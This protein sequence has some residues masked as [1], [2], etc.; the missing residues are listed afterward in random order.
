MDEKSKRRVE[1]NQ[2][3]EIRREEIKS[4][5]I[6]EFMENGIEKS[7]IYDIA[8]RAGVGEATIY[9]YFETKPKL[10]IQSAVKLWRNSVEELIPK[11]SSESSKNLN[12][13]EKIEAILKLFGSIFEK[14]PALLRLLEQFDNYIVKECVPMEQLQQFA[15]GILHVRAVTA[16]IIR[17]GQRDGSIRPEIDSS[18]FYLSS[19]Q[20]ILTLSQKLLMRG[21]IIQGEEGYSPKNQIADL[22]DMQLY[23]IRGK[24]KQRL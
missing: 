24:A 3:I 5:A 18:R 19:I 20:T 14:K 11:I 13:Y 7:K 9:R 8:K 4:A 6:C 2:Q 22:I 23:Y 1:L 17:E 21:N 15:E 10:V 12:G 16:D